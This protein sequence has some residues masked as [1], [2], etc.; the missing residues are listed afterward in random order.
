MRETFNQRLL[1]DEDEYLL[2]VSEV[3]PMLRVSKGV[4]YRLAQQGL[5][6]EKRCGLLCIKKSDVYDFAGLEGPDDWLLRTDEVAAVL[7]TSIPVVN[8]WCK[9]NGIGVHIGKMWRIPFSR[10]KRF[11]KAAYDIDLNVE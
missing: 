2:T 6:F 8:R 10:L 4:L 1:K 7:G 3:A 5:H 11:V 9:Q